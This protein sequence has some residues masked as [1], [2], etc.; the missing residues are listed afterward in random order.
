[1]RTIH[2]HKAMLGICR[3]RAQAE[4]ANA[5]FWHEKASILE[6]LIANEKR[7]SLLQFSKEKLKKAVARNAVNSDSVKT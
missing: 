5:S 7:L 3:E 4:R 1:M 2:H 6:Q